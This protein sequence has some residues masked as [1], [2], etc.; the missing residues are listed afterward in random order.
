MTYGVL[1]SSWM[2]HNMREMGTLSSN[3]LLVRDYQR[4]DYNNRYRV[5]RV[6][7]RRLNRLIDG[8]RLIVDLWCSVV[9]DS[10]ADRSNRL[11]ARLPDYLL[12]FEHK[13]DKPYCTCIAIFKEDID[14]R[15]FVE[16]LHSQIYRP[17]TKIT[18]R[19]LSSH[20]EFMN[21]VVVVYLI[22]H[23]DAYPAR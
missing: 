8:E 13:K 10:L 18:C 21:L 16:F 3:M 12:T 7:H 1:L 23:L 11:R 9:E 5:Y 4:I 15:N 20:D 14:D 6:I 19:G 22:K 17:G 2:V